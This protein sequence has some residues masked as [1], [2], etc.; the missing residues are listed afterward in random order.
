MMNI[1]DIRHHSKY[2]KVTIIVLVY[3]GLK[4][5]DACLQS[6]LR[7]NYLNYEVVIVDNK[8]SDES[9]RYILTHYPDIKV[10]ENRKNYGTA[11][12]NNI[13]MRY[14][15]KSGADYVV[16][17][18]QDIIVSPD[19]LIEMVNVAETH[20]DIG[21]LSPIQYDYKGEQIDLNFRKILDRTSYFDDVEKDGIKEYY[22]FN[23]TIAASMM[24]R[25]NVLERINMFDEIYFIYNEDPDF[26]RRA[27]YHGYRVTGIPK[28]KVNH[29][30]SMIKKHLI[31]EKIRFFI[32]R[33][34]I[35][36]YLKDPKHSFIY[37]FKDT[38]IWAKRYKNIYP[39]MEIR[40][41]TKVKVVLSII[42]LIPIVYFHHKMDR[43]IRG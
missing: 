28:S 35:I 40:F 42:V 5:L 13:G 10:I 1:N 24:I 21:V 11:K 25:R 31:P 4:W 30:H 23:E 36:Y 19:W 15:L 43:T 14:A 41:G 33:N 27:I 32:K 34:R 39:E 8:S 26:C 2:P 37:N 3:N 17:L 6:L 7:T 29:N 22:D 9:V 16:L 38:F 18:N 20:K 12:G